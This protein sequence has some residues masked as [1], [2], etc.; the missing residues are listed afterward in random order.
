MDGMTGEESAVKDTDFGG[1]TMALLG[2]HPTDLD[3]LSSSLW[4]FASQLMY[5]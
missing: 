4:I 5:V 3:G 2:W 1:Q